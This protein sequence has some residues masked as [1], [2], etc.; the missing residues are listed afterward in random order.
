MTGYH[1]PVLSKIFQNAAGGGREQY[2]AAQY[3]V[4][5]SGCGFVMSADIVDKLVEH[6]ASRL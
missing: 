5:A 6:K 1:T 4:F 3:P 2:G